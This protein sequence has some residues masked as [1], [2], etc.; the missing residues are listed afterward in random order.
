MKVMSFFEFKLQKEFAYED[1]Y[2]KNAKIRKQYKQYLKDNNI[3]G[4][5]YDGKQGWW[6]YER[7]RPKKV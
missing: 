1:T 2:N 6:L 4:Y 7:K 3:T 5:Y